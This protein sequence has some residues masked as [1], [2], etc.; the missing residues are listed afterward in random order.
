MSLGADRAPRV[1]LTDGQERSV[2]AACRSLRRA[3]YLVDATASERPAATH[4]SRS[5]GTRYMVA[6]TLAH[7]RRFVED[8]RRIVAA[9]GHGALLI[10]TDQSLFA[11]SRHRE[12]LEPLVALGLPPPDAVDRSLSNLALTEAGRSAGVPSPEIAICADRSEALEA[13]R[14]FGYP[15]VVKPSQA[16]FELDGSLRKPRTLLIEDESSLSGLPD[17]YGSPFLLQRFESGEVFSVGGVFAS[18]R[19]VAH[20]A[21]R[22]WRT[23]PPHAGNVA[24]SETVALPGQLERAIPQF[25]GEMGWEG[26]FELELI[27]RP[28]SGFR[29][30]DFNPRV[31][32]SLALA[33]SAGAPLAVSWCDRLLE[34]ERP[35]GNA[36]PR[37]R[38]REEEGELKNLLWRLRRRRFGDALAMLRPRARTTH[39]HLRTTDPLPLLALA[40][41]RS[42]RMA[43]RKR[44]EGPGAKR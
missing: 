10:G 42:L 8:L 39:A 5:C 15:V 41:S 6:D 40:V 21:S 2:L 25:V 28:D 13:A 34:R 4:W 1:L 20:A 14:R 12:Q 24:F 9:D 17:D 35:T 27:Y 29:A 7:P 37:Y 19:L 26:I 23:W 32:G 22:Y 31:Y 43:R 33:A 16:V 11:V 44:V 36:R 30:I 3:G 38:Y 18:G